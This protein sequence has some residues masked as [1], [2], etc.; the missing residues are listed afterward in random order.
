M[1]YGVD[2]CRICGTPIIPRG[3]DIA[4]EQEKANRKPIIPEKEWRK[5]GFLTSPTRVQLYLD[6]A[7]GCCGVCGL[8]L[9]KKTY[10]YNTMAL[11]IMGVVVLLAVGVVFIVTY[12]PH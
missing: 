4:E 1:T 8:K 6:P 12:L 5:R 2:Q 10:R 11:S 3:P 9:M 7:N